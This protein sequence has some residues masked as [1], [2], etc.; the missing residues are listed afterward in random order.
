MF[1]ATAEK[2]GWG[3]FLI[4]IARLRDSA[5]LEQARAEMIAIAAQRALEVPANNTGWS[6]TVVPLAEQ[7]TGEV[8]TALVVLLGA[9]A[10][11]L[12]MAVTNVATLTVSTMRRRG[13]ELA[14]RRAIGATDG[15]LF[16]Q[17]FTQSALLAAIGTGAGLLVAPLGVRLLVLTM[18]PDIPRVSAIH[19]DGPVLLVT[20]LIA[21]LATCLFG[22]VAAIKGRSAS[23]L[24]S[25]AEIAGQTRASSHPGGGALVITEIQY[26][27][28]ASSSVQASPLRVWVAAIDASGIAMLCGNCTKRK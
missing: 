21:V 5:T 23:R 15:R 9:V 26:P 2:R 27:A 12:T 18:P 22:S 4:V 19:V 11:L 6:A 20:S 1:T 28:A 8:R 24:P 17:L 7:I 14:V 25:T 16:R 13:Q 3:R 10:L